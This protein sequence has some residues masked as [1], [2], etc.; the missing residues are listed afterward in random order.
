MYTQTYIHRISPNSNNK[1]TN[2]DNELTIGGQH[3]H[4]ADTV[5]STMAFNTHNNSMRQ[6]L[7]VILSFTIEDND[8]QRDYATYP[9]SKDEKAAEPGIRLP[10]PEPSLSTTRT[11]SPLNPNSF[12][13]KV[14]STDQN[15]AWNRVEH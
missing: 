10:A 11:D 14:E 2:N 1:E 6:G 3:N 5:L 15:L 12:R 8:I 7:L 4:L 13:L 9:R